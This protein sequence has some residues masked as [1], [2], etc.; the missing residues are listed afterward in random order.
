M[1]DDELHPYERE[2]HKTKASIQETVAPTQAR[3]EGY[4]HTDG[5]WKIRYGC[6]QLS[7][8][9]YGKAEVA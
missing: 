8:D 6:R 1:I 2:K 5:K 4:A 9:G 7:P 3:G